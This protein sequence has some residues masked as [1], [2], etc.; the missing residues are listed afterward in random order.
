M[1]RSAT[2]AA[3]RQTSVRLPSALYERLAAAAG[4]RGIGDEIR[5]RLERS[6]H[7]DQRTAELAELLSAL[8]TSIERDRGA[9]W[10]ADPAAY[11]AFAAG[12]AALVEAMKPKGEPGSPEGDDPAI[13]GRTLA[14]VTLAQ[15]FEE[16]GHSPVEHRVVVSKSNFKLRKEPGR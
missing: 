12:L 15:A 5:A 8:A 14:R 9:P 4:E 3:D 16:W 10:H 11:S 1:P 2:P 13:V 6:F 7:Q